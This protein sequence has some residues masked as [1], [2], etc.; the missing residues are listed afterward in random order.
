SPKPV[1]PRMRD[2]NYPSPRFSPATFAPAL[3]LRVHLIRYVY[4]L[5]LRLLSVPALLHSLCPY[6]SSV[7]FALLALA[8][9]SLPHPSS[10]P[11]SS[12]RGDWLVRPLSQAAPP[13]LR[14]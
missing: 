9:L 6:I 8:F 13:W 4:S 12:P 1:Q 14:L 5:S 3:L 7:S 11:P 10:R 2:L